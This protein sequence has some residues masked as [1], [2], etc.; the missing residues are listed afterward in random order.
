MKIILLLLLKDNIVVI[1]ENN[2]VVIVENITSFSKRI[3]V[4]Q[5]FFVP[6]QALLRSKLK[7]T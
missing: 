7:N 5:N 4:I 3:C 6:L 1:V 2:I